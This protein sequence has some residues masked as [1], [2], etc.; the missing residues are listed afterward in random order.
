MIFFNPL[1]GGAPAPRMRRLF[2]LVTLTVLL[3]FIC[4]APL[5]AQLTGK[6]SISGT[7][8]DKTGAVIPNA[9]LTATNTG[10]GLTSKTVSNG[11]G[12]FRF[13]SLDPGIYTL[14]VA[15]PGFQKLAQQN[16]HVNAMET[17][18]TTRFW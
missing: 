5:S 17:L 2:G 15:A 10:N 14:T 12:G 4:A 7:V 6:G 13:S 3:A 11:T 16:L 8:A 9:S 18:A 1:S